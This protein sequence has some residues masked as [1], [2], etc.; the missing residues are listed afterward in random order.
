MKK[1]Y[2]L[3][4][5]ATIL[6]SSF[7]FAQTTF[8]FETAIDGED[9]T[10]TIDGI[11]ITVSLSSGTERL[12]SIVN[13]TTVAPTN[14]NIDNLAIISFS[15]PVDANSIVVVDGDGSGATWTFTPTGGTNSIVSESVDGNFSTVE[16]NWTDI[17]SFQI[18]TSN[19]NELDS[20]IIGDIIV[21]DVILST[22]DFNTNNVNVNVTAYPNPVS[23]ILNVTAT[24]TTIESVTVYNIQGALVLTTNETESID[25]SSLSSGVYLA[26]ISTTDGNITKTIVKQ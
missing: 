18:T 11:T 26:K 1:N 8:G 22:N 21:N 19:I 7:N 10:E 24:T 16:L 20:F 17:T 14:V 13:N 12:L 6:I 25:L 5:L 4:F 9:I 2:T 15:E 3:T 23:N